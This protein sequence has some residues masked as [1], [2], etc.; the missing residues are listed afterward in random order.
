MVVG[1][2]AERVRASVQDLDGVSVCSNPDWQ[3][4]LA[5]SLRTGLQE[6]RKDAQ[7]EGLLVTV[8]DQPHI[9][10]DILT[11]L[12]DSFA[13]GHRL[14][15]S[16]YHGVLGVPAVFGKEYFDDLSRLSGDQGAGS[17]LRARASN[18]QSIAVSDAEIDID[19]ESD[20]NKLR[21]HESR[22]FAGPRAPLGTE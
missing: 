3:S 16:E 7:V 21:E 22:S 2:D 17:W 19:T 20:V 9:S 13:S 6:V 4:G 5:S 1:A 12:T 18:V 11:Q 8:S 15:A 10:V 14:V